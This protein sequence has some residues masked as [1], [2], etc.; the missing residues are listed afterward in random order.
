MPFFC[1]GEG[2]KEA[3]EDHLLSWYLLPIGTFYL[4]SLR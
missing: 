3:N 1:M 2:V 4:Q